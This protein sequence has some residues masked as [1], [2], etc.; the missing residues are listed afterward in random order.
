[1]THRNLLLCAVIALFASMP[2]CGDDDPNV[3][4]GSGGSGGSGGGDTE[5]GLAMC[6]ALGSLCHAVDDG[7]GPLADC[8]DLGHAAD[9]E[10]CVEGFQSCIDLCLEA[11]EHGAGGAGGQGGAG[12]AG[13]PGPA[14]G[15]PLCE[16]IGS[17]C[18]EVDDVDGPLHACHE[19]GHGG[20]AEACAAQAESCITMCAAAREGLGGAG[21]GGGSG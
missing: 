9:P 4:P 21:G 3:E 13:A 17:Y 6:R 2:A 19:L 20:D 1:M 10:A 5:L 8:H 18:H 12:H 11:E 15:S 16:F 14:P 7:D